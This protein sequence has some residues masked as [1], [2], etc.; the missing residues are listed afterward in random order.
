MV[1]FSANFTFLK[2]KNMDKSNGT[3]LL[4]IANR[5]TRRMLTF[6][7]H[8]DAT[9]GGVVYTGGEY[10]DAANPTIESDFGD[11]FLMENGFSLFWVGWQFDVPASRTAGSRIFIPKIDPENIIE[12][13]VRSDFVVTSEVFDRTLADR[14]HIPYSV[15]DPDSP[16]NILTV[17]D[18]VEGE[19]RIIARDQWSFARLEQ[20]KVVPDMDRIYLSSGFKPKQIYEVVYV[21][22]NP[23][24]IGLGLAAIR[25][26]ASALKY[27]SLVD[28]NLSE[29]SI[30]HII[31]YG[32]CLLYTSPSPRDR[33]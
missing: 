5:G 19:R 13:L 10:W 22:E 7:N 16:E 17:R 23:E 15:S 18:S 27:D 11:G 12:G 33:G 28:L 31:A 4:G 24:I 3:T 2:P 9:D 30:D 1:E 14:G 21:S 6:F 32:I 29:N 20:G 25:D 8:A 26:T